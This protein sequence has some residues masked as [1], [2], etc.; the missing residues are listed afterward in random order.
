MKKV[1]RQIYKAER[2]HTPHY[3]KLDFAAPTLFVQIGDYITYPRKHGQEHEHE[4]QDA[5]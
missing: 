2:E 4:I 3:A 5:V 1:D